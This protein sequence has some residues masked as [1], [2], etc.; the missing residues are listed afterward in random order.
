M[1]IDLH[2]ST[3]SNF[4]SAHFYESIKDFAVVFQEREPKAKILQFYDDYF[5]AGAKYPFIDSKYVYY[6]LTVI[7]NKSKRDWKIVWICWDNDE[8]AL[9]PEFRTI[10]FMIYNKTLIKVC[11]SVPEEFANKIK[12][13]RYVFFQDKR[14]VEPV[15]HIENLN[16]LVIF[17]NYNQNFVDVVSQKVSAILWEKGCDSLN[18]KWSLEINDRD[19]T[20]TIGDKKYRVITLSNSIAQRIRLGLCWD[21]DYDVSDYIGDTDIRIDITKM[22]F[23]K[24]VSSISE[25][26]DFVKRGCFEFNY[27][28]RT[29]ME[30]L[31][32]MIDNDAEKNNKD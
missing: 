15:I 29:A 8:S 2:S 14:S 1:R 16:P 27:D 24:G 20:R 9:K 18:P 6:P 10:P 4:M 32:N 26:V 5:L 17:G 12:G 21:K 22:P 30:Y 19:L 28:Y 7:Y 3:L 23:A 11:D 25:A 13:K 31:H